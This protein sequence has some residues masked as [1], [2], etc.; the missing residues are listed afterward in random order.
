MSSGQT[1]AFASPRS[2]DEE[3]CEG[4]EQYQPLLPHPC[5]HLSGCFS[6]ILHKLKSISDLDPCYTSQLAW[7]RVCNGNSSAQEHGKHKG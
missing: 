4:F 6:F 5:L 2:E 1:L 7:R 3:D